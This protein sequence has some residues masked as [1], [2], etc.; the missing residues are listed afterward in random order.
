MDYRSEAKNSLRRAKHE[1]DKGDDERLKYAALELRMALES[2]IYKRA[3][4]YSEELSG[5]KLSTWQPK[6]LLELLLKIDPNADK[7]TSVSYGI[8]E[9]QGKSAQTMTPLGNERVLSLAEI[10]RYYVRLS[11]FV[12]APTLEQIGKRASPETIRTRCNEIIE[13]LEQ[14]LASPIFNVNFK[15]AT[16][17]L[18]KQCNAKIVRRSPSQ[19]AGFVIAECMEC[20]ASYKLIPVGDKQVEWQDL[21]HEIECVNPSCNYRNKIWDRDIKLNSRWTCAECS[22]DQMI[23]YEVRML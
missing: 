4:L 13:I 14:V 10:K 15:I 2:L 19:E 16:S 17:I 7:S 3:S 9:E 21:I 23:V 12:H 8:E 18:C 5:K 20:S 11:S 22:T 1:I 6:I